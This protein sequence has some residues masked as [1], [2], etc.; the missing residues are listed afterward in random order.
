MRD[1]LVES[2]AYLDPQA[3]ILKPDVVFEICQEIVKT[4]DPFARTLNSVNKALEIL[5][6]AVA[7]KELV[8]EEREAHWLDLLSSQVEEIPEDE[9]E[10]IAEMRDEINP[11]NCKLDEYGL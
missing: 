6:R 10:F 5:R 9:E 2:D 4:Q 8:L 3:Y 11:A 1:L 7:N